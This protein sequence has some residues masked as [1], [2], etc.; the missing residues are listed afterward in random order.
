MKVGT[1]QEIPY[2]LASGCATLFKSTRRSELRSSR[3]SSNV[4]ELCTFCRACCVQPQWSMVTSLHKMLCRQRQRQ[5]RT[6]EWCGRVLPPSCSSC[7]PDSLS[8]TR[9]AGTC[10]TQTHAVRPQRSCPCGCWRACTTPAEVLRNWRAAE[11]GADTLL[12]IVHM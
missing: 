3:T 6:W 7:K 4:G 11:T 5:R 12:V 9:C 10:L 1:L 2:L 8:T